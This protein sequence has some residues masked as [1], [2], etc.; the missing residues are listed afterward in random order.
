M[1]GLQQLNLWF[2]YHFNTVTGFPFRNLVLFFAGMLKVIITKNTRIGNEQ[3]QKEALVAISLFSIL[4]MAKS[5]II[6]S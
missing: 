2:I 4:F 6:S 5:A 1:Y 3:F